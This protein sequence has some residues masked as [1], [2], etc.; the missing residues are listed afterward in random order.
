MN[1]PESGIRPTKNRAAALSRRSSPARAR[2]L[3]QTIPSGNNALGIM[4]TGSGKSLYYQLPALFLARPALKV[5]PL[6]SLV[7]D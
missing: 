5:S 3:I 2:E 7:Q 1:T 4:T 6:I